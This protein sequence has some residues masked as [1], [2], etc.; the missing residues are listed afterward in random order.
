[1]ASKAGGNDLG[2]GVASFELAHIS[3]AEVPLRQESVP[4]SPPADA[5]SQGG[6]SETEDRWAAAVTN[7]QEASTLL[8][9]LKQLLLVT[10]VYDDETKFRDRA[11][12][13]YQGRAL[14][15][16]ERRI[17]ALE[18]EVDAAVAAAGRARSQVK[19]AEGARREAEERA[20]RMQADLGSTAAVFEVH[21]DELAAV[22]S[23]VDKK[24]D[25]IHVLKAI[26]K[27]LSEKPSSVRP[28]ARRLS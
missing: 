5:V 8:D 25:E 7:L 28:G 21:K 4:P 12:V 3:Q 26:I 17:K 23:I 18:R 13:A 1:M 22:Q 20:A 11:A 15:A 19:E 9:T 14:Q 10:A 6:A 16:R 27:T 24:D 2:R